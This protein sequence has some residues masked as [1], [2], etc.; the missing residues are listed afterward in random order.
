M[1]KEK[2]NQLLKFLQERCTVPI[3]VNINALDDQKFPE[4]SIFG[5]DHAVRFGF[6]KNGKV[7]VRSK[8]ADEDCTSLKN[9]IKAIKTTMLNLGIQH[10]KGSDVKKLQIARLYDERILSLR[11]EHNQRFPYLEMPESCNVSNSMTLSE[12]AGT[13]L[14][15]NYLGG[16]Y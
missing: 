7:T 4:I 9:W 10:A 3:E 12:N 1:E 16:G 2:A 11:Q 13:D 5:G 15:R 8:F 14:L 6:L